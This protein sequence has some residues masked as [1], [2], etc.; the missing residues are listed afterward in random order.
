MPVL[1]AACASS[2]RRHRLGDHAH[3]RCHAQALF[4][5]VLEAEVPADHGATLGLVA[6]QLPGALAL[7]KAHSLGDQIRLVFLHDGADLRG[8]HHAAKIR[9]L[10][11]EWEVDQQQAVLRH[12]REGLQAV[13][14]FFAVF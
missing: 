13:V 7:A 14:V 3:P 9:H 8:S 2:S 4:I 10:P 5:V 12:Q 1:A 11:V 6:H